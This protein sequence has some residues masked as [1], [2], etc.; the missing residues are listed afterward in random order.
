VRDRLMMGPPALLDVVR[1]VMG[2]PPRLGRLYGYE[3][4][5]AASVNRAVEAAV[6]YGA[7]PY[8]AWRHKAG[9]LRARLQEQPN[10]WAYHYLLCFTA[11]ELA[12]LAEALE[13]A[14]H[15]QALRPTDPRSPNALGTVYAFIATVASVNDDELFN[16]LLNLP[17]SFTTES[18]AKLMAG[19]G[20]TVE[21]AAQQAHQWFQRTLEAGLHPQDRQAL[22]WSMATVRRWLAEDAAD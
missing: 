9:V 7:D 22:E 15:M 11:L 8:A 18:C 5:L 21:S 2:R 10:E 20:L 4:G 14:T 1:R 19:L 16:L 6:G 3:K 13:A 12:E 17:A